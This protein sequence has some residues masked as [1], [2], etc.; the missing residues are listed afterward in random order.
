MLKAKGY[1]LTNVYPLQVGGFV[2]PDIYR[3]AEKTVDK[4]DLDLLPVKKTPYTPESQALHP[5]DSIVTAINRW[6]QRLPTQNT[7]DAESPTILKGSIDAIFFLTVR[8]R[9]IGSGQ[10]IASALL[11]GV[12]SG[13][14]SGGRATQS[15]WEADYINIELS[16][17]D[18]ESGKLLYRM[19]RLEK[20]YS[21]NAAMSLL[22]E[23][24]EKFPSVASVAD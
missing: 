14:L 8:G 17:I 24:K 1:P 15:Q 16:V 23:F 20:S 9:E 2:K 11:T 19:S 4:D 12:L 13:L 22:E 21:E 3:V 10:Q 18:R 7:R 5:D 6:I